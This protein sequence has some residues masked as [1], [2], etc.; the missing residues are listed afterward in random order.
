MPFANLL[1][2]IRLYRSYRDRGDA[3][4]LHG[5]S[6]NPSNWRT[7][8]DI[9]NRVAELYRRRYPDFGPTFAAE[10]PAEDEGVNM[11]VSTLRRLLMEE[12]LWHGK[13]RIREYRSRREPRSRFGEPVPFD[14]IPHDWFEGR[15]PRCCLI[16]M[17]CDIGANIS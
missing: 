14:G 10:K 6:G 4:L 7:A 17:L 2:V 3:G 12:G 15:R 11:S 5:S 9:R 16:I 13:R 8:V 1:T